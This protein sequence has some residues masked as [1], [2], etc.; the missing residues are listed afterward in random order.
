M[1]HFKRKMPKNSA[2]P[3]S[4]VRGNEQISD[5]NESSWAYGDCDG[6]FGPI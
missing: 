3:A 4:K 6:N 2:V 1:N 5:L